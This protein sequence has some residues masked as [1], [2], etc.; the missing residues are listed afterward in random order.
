[1]SKI[2][3]GAKR[4]FPYAQVNVGSKAGA[5]GGGGQVAMPEQRYVTKSDA[6]PHTTDGPREPR[7]E[8][9]WQSCVRS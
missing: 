5:V 7:L 3:G 9:S 8:E 4:T 6:H 1:M 2:P